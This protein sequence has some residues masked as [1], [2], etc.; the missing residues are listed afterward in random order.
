M[1][2]LLNA[3]GYFQSNVEAFLAEL[4]PCKKARLEEFNLYSKKERTL[5]NLEKR[6][7][8]ICENKYTCTRDRVF[9]LQKS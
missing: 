5:L 3:I 7:F 8:A 9:R 2:G 4:R 6:Q 1:R